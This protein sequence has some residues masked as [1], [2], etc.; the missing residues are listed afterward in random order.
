MTRTGKIGRLP[1]TVREELNQRLSN[2][3]EG[4]TLLSWLNALPLVQES[5]Q[6]HH[7]GS[8]ITKQN[9][10][11]WRQGGFRES[12]IRQEWTQHAREL[13]ESA[14]EL[15]QIVETPLI[16]CDLAAV[17]AARYAALLNGWDGEPDPKFEEKVRLLRGLN[18]DIAL[19][20][21]TLQRAAQQKK[22]FNQNLDDIDRRTDE[23]TK[24]AIVAP[25]WAKLESEE[26][27]GIFGGGERG[28]KMADMVTAVKYDLPRPK[29]RKEAKEPQAESASEQ[30]PSQPAS[31]AQSNPVQPSPTKFR[32]VQA[33]RRLRILG[34]VLREFNQCRLSPSHEPQPQDPSRGQRNHCPP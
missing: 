4:E 5:L 6:E 28:Q 24:K 21:K 26:L 3:E 23:E 1:C 10:S 30:P 34:I 31:P 8:P 33:L 11:E 25:I 20:Q 16:A 19:L 13:F 12:E 15:D 18:Q 7:D 9:L 22:D 2:G 14:M 17:L 29:F 32:R 27:A